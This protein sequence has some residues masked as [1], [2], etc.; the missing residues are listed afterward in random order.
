MVALRLR[1]RPRCDVIDQGN[2]YIGKCKRLH[3]RVVR[4]DLISTAV[5]QATVSDH[6]VGNVPHAFNRYHGL[7]EC[8]RLA[9]KRDETWVGR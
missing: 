8:N 2:I 3:F 6:P 4:L 9:F 5:T 1:F 7:T